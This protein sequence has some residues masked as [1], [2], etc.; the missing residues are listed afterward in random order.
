MAAPSPVFLVALP[1]R[2]LLECPPQ[3]KSLV[4][5]S[6]QGASPLWSLPVYLTAPRCLKEAPERQL[7]WG[8]PWP[9]SP[10]PTLTFLLPL[11][12]GVQ[13]GSSLCPECCSSRHHGAWVLYSDAI[14]WVKCS[15]VPL[16][17]SLFVVFMVLDFPHTKALSPLGL[18][19]LS[20]RV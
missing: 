16:S 19:G 14:F 11:P 5:Q 15:W 10:L 8:F 7:V 9:P 18:L 4:F 6:P 3:S 20:L 13:G 17:L 12:G 1:F 2:E